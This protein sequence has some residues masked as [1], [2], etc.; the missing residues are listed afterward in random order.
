[1]PVTDD[2]VE[3]YIKKVDEIS[4][5]IADL[6]IDF[7]ER[8]GGIENEVRQLSHDL[9]RMEEKRQDDHDLLIEV[10]QLVQA[11]PDAIRE[12][13]SAV[14]QRVDKLQTVSTLEA[15]KAEG[16]REQRAVMLKWISGIVGIIAIVGY[17]GRA[18]AEVTH[19]TLKT[20]AVTH[21]RRNND[22][23]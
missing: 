17:L 8:V 19:P 7:K 16:R 9:V 23:T 4:G 15:G 11:I 1:M 14:H 20:E 3:Q 13:V 12:S 22:A 10:K 21:D 5:H 2:K 18:D 6:E